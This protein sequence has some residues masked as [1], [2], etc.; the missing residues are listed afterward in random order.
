LKRTNYN[1]FYGSEL[2]LNSIVFLFK[3]ISYLVTGCM[4]GV[5][6][7]EYFERLSFY[8]A[9]NTDNDI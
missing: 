1:I 9:M 2:K 6:L 5:R 8:E 3:I 7:L 4:W